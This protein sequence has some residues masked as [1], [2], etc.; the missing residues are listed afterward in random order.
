MFT[1]GFLWWIVTGMKN[2][3]CNDFT[4]F[5]LHEGNPSAKVSGAVAGTTSTPMGE[6][7][8]AAVRPAIRPSQSNAISADVLGSSVTMEPPSRG[9]PFSMKSALNV[10]LEFDV[11]AQAREL[12]FALPVRVSR[13][14][15]ESLLD[16]WSPCACRDCE[17]KALNV[18]KDR[19]LRL[20]KGLRAAIEAL[21]GDAAEVSFSLDI[22]VGGCSHNR[23]LLPLVASVRAPAVEGVSVLIALGSEPLEEV[24]PQHDR[25]PPPSVRVR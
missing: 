10:P 23:Q 19:L 22:P 7:W 5:I 13:R 2:L 3:P 6:A 18:S 15:R 11:S 25:A 20:L 12:G 1:P 16:V 24:R 4:Q 17:E 14:L 8:G 9:L 21:E